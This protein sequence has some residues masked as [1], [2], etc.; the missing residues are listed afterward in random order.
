MNTDF[1]AWSQPTLANFAA[2]S[3]SQLIENA[4]QIKDLQEQLRVAIDAYRQL[5]IKVG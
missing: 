3:Y 4:A 1:H 2:A 5:V